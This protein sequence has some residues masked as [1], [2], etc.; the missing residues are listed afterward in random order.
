MR[1]SQQRRQECTELHPTSFPFT[2]A[3]FVP[4]AASPFPTSQQVAVVTCIHSSQFHQT[5]FNIIVL[6]AF[7]PPHS[8]SFTEVKTDA[9]NTFHWFVS[10][11][12][13]FFW[14]NITARFTKRNCKGRLRQVHYQLLDSQS[15]SLSIIHRRL[16]SPP[17][18]Q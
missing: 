16:S 10:Q 4:N 18:R 15:A 5:L 1:R 6:V 2:A 3:F 13:F 17:S 14:S 8:K 7:V 9:L 12:F 11:R